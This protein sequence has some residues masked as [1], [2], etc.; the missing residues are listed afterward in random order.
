MQAKYQVGSDPAVRFV[1]LL[2]AALSCGSGERT[3]RCASDCGNFG[4]LAL[5]PVGMVQV[6]RTLEG[7]PRQVLH[8]KANDLIGPVSNRCKAEAMMALM[9]KEALPLSGLSGYPSTRDVALQQFRP[10]R[11]LCGNERRTI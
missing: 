11:R 6:R 10:D 2:Q 8:L 7:R 1:A 4:L 5:T 9:G 3:D